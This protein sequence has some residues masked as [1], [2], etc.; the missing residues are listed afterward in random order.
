MFALIRH[1][2]S[3]IHKDSALLESNL[4]MPLKD[5]GIQQFFQNGVTAQQEAFVGTLKCLYRLCKEKIAYTT[6]YEQLTDLAKFLGFTYLD[7]LFVR[8]NAKYT[9]ETFFARSAGVACICCQRYY[10]F[11]CENIASL[12]CFN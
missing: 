4:K 1:A 9:S 7:N 8:E 2:N 5:G 6:K 12:F 3:D 11:C 10:S